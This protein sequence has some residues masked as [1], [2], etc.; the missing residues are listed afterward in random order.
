MINH[1]Y[2]QPPQTI[3]HGRMNKPKHRTVALI[4]VWNDVTVIIIVLL[5][6]YTILVRDVVLVMYQQ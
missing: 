4:S 5:E 3:E 1:E 6:W 2:A